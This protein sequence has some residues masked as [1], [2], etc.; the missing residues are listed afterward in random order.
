MKSIMSYS[1]FLNE[2]KMLTKTVKKVVKVSFDCDWNKE[3]GKVEDEFTLVMSSDSTGLYTIGENVEKYTGIPQADTI[4]DVKAGKETEKDAIV[5]GVCAPMN[6]GGEIFMWHNGTRLA[7]VAKEKGIWQAI[8]E[9]ISH[10]STHMAIIIVTRAIAKKLGARIDNDEWIKYDY[11]SGANKFIWP[12]IGTNNDKKNPIVM[13]DEESFCTTVGYVV[14]AV[15]PHF[16]EM[17][18]AYIPQLSA[19]SKI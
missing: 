10:E 7:G 18:S 2:E 8:S 17:A 1:S 4:R 13:V 11:G 19:I 14:E 9:Q 6:N 5:Y 16:L 3:I 15:F 12:A